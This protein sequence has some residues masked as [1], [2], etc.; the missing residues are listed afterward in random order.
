[1]HTIVRFG[2]LWFNKVS[3]FFYNNWTLNIRIKYGRII[4]VRGINEL[5]FNL[6]A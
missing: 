6:E 4:L 1:M 2:N 3:I 5:M